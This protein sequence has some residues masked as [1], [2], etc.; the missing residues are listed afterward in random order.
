MTQFFY[1]LGDLFQTSF[2]VLPILGNYFNLLLVI[3]F[4]VAF[5]ISLK[6]FI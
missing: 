1:W 5:F 6:K 4:S 2:F 3:L